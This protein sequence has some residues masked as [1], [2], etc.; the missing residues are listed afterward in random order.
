[1]KAPLVKYLWMKR[2]YTLIQNPT[3]DI[4]YLPIFHPRSAYCGESRNKPFRPMQN[5]GHLYGRQ[6]TLGAPLVIDISHGRGLV[7]LN[8]NLVALKLLGLENQTK[9]DRSQFQ[10][11]YR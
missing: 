8:P 10:Y 3:A 11:I 4:I 9:S 5:A 2:P 6:G 7:Q 1:M